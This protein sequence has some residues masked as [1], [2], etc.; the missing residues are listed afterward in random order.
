MIT[1]TPCEISEIWDGD[2]NEEVLSI[3][4]N[5]IKPDRCPKCDWHKPFVKTK[6]KRSFHCSRCAF[7]IFPCSNTI[8]E[9]SLV[10]LSYWMIFYTEIVRRPSVTIN[11]LQDWCETDKGKY[12]VSKQTVSRMVR[13]IKDNME[14]D[15]LNVTKNSGIASY[16]SIPDMRRISKEAR[17]AISL[18]ASF[19]NKHHY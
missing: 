4:F 11:A 12:S 17:S 3:L 2:P 10:N 7:Q 1:I 18:A 13:I 14:G 19:N 6:G 16:D 8:F 9:K 15:V 5:K